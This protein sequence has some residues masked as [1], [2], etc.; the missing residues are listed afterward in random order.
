[1][2]A[3]SGLFFVL[4]SV[5]VSLTLY[6]SLRALEIKLPKATAISAGFGGQLLSDVT[7]ARSGYF[8]T[9]ILLREMGNVPIKQGLMSVMATG[10]VNFFTKAIFSTVALVYFLTRFTF[11]PTMTNALLVGIVLLLIGGVGLTILVWTNYLPQFTKKLSRVPLLRTLVSKLDSF[12]NVFQG[13]QNKLKSSIRSISVL[14][15][16][17]IL[18]NSVALFLIARSVGITTPNF[19]DF[20][21]M[22]PIVAA[23]MYVPLTFA[24][25]GLQESVYV[26]ILINLGAPIENALSFAL[27]A[28]ILF[29]GTDLLGVPSLIKAGTS[30]TSLFS[31]DDHE[32]S[33][34]TKTSIS[35]K[36]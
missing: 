36:D 31:S 21:F 1:M 8:A 10:A 4:A 7:P 13:G 19:T 25:L 9:P 11:D 3:V 30:V 12:I 2:I 20:L 14:I 22:V 6:A 34:L 35:L 17:S 24:G 18:L 33:S 26:F 23:F 15:L 29:T 16:A 28:R 27:L 5:A 32:E